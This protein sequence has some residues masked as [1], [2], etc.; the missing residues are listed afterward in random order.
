MKTLDEEH[1]S[2][3]ELKRVGLD[4]CGYFE[5]TWS[6]C[7]SCFGDLLKAKIPKF[8][9]LNSVN[10]V[11]CHEYPMALQDLTIVEECVIAR[12]HPIGAILKLRPGNRRSGANYY[13]LRGHMVVIPQNP[14]PLLD[15][16]PS[17][18]LRL[19]DAIKVMWAK[20]SHRWKT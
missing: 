19:Q 17:P 1:D 2:L 15:I 13:A 6:F 18:S 5:G 11:N 4:K 7:K 16:L 3:K 10:V 8:S 20:V 9:A 12:R 14:G